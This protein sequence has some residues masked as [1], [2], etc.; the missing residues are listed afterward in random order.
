MSTHPLVTQSEFVLVEKILIS[1]ETK[2]LK[3][4]TTTV[5]LIN[6]LTLYTLGFVWA[7]AI[8]LEDGGKT[9]PKLLKELQDKSVVLNQLM[10]LLQ[11]NRVINDKEQFFQ[12]RI[13]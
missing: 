5:F 12:E 10:K 3:I 7:E 1:L 9:D 4:Q 6:S 11:D 2:G 13:A 8:E